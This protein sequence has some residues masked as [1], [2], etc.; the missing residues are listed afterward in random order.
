MALTK[1]TLCNMALSKLGSS[2]VQLSDFDS[3]TGEI[4]SQCALHYEP[5]LHELV[6][7]HKWNCCK[8]RAK[9]A[10]GFTVSGLTG[11]SADSNGLYIPE[12]VSNIGTVNEKWVHITNSSAEFYIDTPAPNTSVWNFIDQ[13]DGAPTATA[14]IGTDITD[15]DVK[16]PYEYTFTGATFT[17]VKD[18]PLFQFK[19]IHTLPTDYIRATYVTNSDEV[20]EYGKPVVDYNIEDNKILSNFE[21]LWMCYEKEP[22]PAAMDSLFAQAFATLLAARLAVPLVGERSLSL[23]LIEEFN[24]VIMPEARRINAFEKRESPTVD[25]EWLEATY[26]SGSSY[27]NSY[28]PFSQTS[29]GSF[30]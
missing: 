27:S 10:T 14:T 19:H 20:Y 25:S 5:T 9:L 6:R 22:T 11:S 16:R 2:R 17:S 4:K 12:N 24:K 28:P 18:A 29:Y 23:S 13:D 15:A 8:A 21:N 7:M 1:T 26:T 30:S 3:D